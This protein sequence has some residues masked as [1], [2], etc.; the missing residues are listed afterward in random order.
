MLSWLT[1]T[2]TAWSK[3]IAPLR[4]NQTPVLSCIAR[5]TAGISSQLQGESFLPIGPIRSED[6]DCTYPIL[7][8]AAGRSQHLAHKSR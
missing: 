8:L 1:R 3:S 2:P 5:L 6:L 4:S 7:E